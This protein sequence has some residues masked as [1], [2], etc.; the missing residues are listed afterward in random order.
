MHCR[1]DRDGGT[2]LQNRGLCTT[3]GCAPDKGWGLISI[4]QAQSSAASLGNQYRAYSLDG[5]VVPE[6]RESPSLVGGWWSW[7]GP[8]VASVFQGTED[9]GSAFGLREG[10]IGL[11]SCDKHPVEVCSPRAEPC[12]GPGLP[13]RPQ[14]G[15]PGC[16]ELAQL[17]GKATWC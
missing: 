14:P 15:L 8:W 7:F 5:S 11:L 3:L 1:R 9:G 2:H 12:R 10:T 4:H 6:K 16:S 13:A 17:H